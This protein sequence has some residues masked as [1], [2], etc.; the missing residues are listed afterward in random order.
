MVGRTPPPWRVLSAHGEL[1]LSESAVT[2]GAALKPRDVLSSGGVCVC[3]L[4]VQSG[5]HSLIHTAEEGEGKLEVG[6]M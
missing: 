2:W 5:A 4:T 1:A 3:V 6:R